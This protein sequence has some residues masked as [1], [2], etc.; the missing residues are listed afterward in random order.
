MSQARHQFR[1]RG[2]SRG[3]QNRTTVPQVV[4][5]KIGPLGGVARGVEPPVQRGGGAVPAV[6]GW[7]EQSVALGADEPLEVVL[8]RRQEV[9]WYRDVT[10]TGVAF[11]CGDL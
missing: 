2:A 6:L 4:P 3:G 5:P 1:E 11:G 10:N 9:R 8:D 7:E